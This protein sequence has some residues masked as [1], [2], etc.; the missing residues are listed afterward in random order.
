MNP[1]KDTIKKNRPNLSESSIRTYTSILKNLYAHV[2]PTDKEIDLEK[3]NETS[4]IIDFLKD[5]PFQRR[6]TYLSALYILSKNTEYQQLML[7]DIKET[8]E[9]DDK[10]EMTESEKANW[11]SQEEIKQLFIKYTK[12]IKSVLAEAKPLDTKTY[13]Y[14]QSYIILALMT[15]L[16]IP[17][18]RLKDWCDLKIKNIDQAKDN[19]IDTVGKGKKS[20][21]SFIFNSYK[22]A[23]FYGAEKVDIPNDLLK[24]I[25]KFIVLNPNDYLLTDS[26]GH[27][28]TP[29]KL[30]QRLNKIFGKQVSCNILRHSYLTEK[31]KNIPALQEMQDTAS[32]MGHS[33]TLALLY[34]KKPAGEK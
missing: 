16:F 24:I 31:Y 32:A 33:L 26:H 8:K 12:V 14:F 18:R 23:K 1:L 7:A 17:P 19:Y 5:I 10:Q 4:K 22:T 20:K 25:N 11:I 6:K 15:G 9:Q 29:V 34:V 13:Q 2:F 27:Q 21:S 30:N 3:F 28:L